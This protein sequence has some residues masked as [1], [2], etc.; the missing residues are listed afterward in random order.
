MDKLLDLDALADEGTRIVIGGEEH[1]MRAVED[2]GLK[3]IANIRKL[4]KAISAKWEHIDE[5]ADDDLVSIE[6]DLSAFVKRIVPTLSDAT[7]ELLGYKKKLAILQ[8]FTGAARA[9]AQ[10]VAASPE[11]ESE[12]PKEIPASP[13]QTEPSTG[14]MPSPVSSDSSAEIPSD[15]SPSPSE[16]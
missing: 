10:T 3:E 14:V 12:Q 9:P 7:L 6:A 15:G 8:A 4:G 1:L 2:F 16:S 11:P 5:L 13:T